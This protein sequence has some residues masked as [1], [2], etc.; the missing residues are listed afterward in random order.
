MTDLAYEK[1]SKDAL[2]LISTATNINHDSSH[3]DRVLE[4]ALSIANIVDPYK[5][6][7]DRNILKTCVLLH[8]L[9]Y[10]EYKTNLYTWWFEGS[11]ALKVLNKKIDLSFL[12]EEERKIISEAIYRHV[13]SFPIRTLN[14]KRNLYVQIL[15]DADTLDMFSDDRFKSITVNIQNSKFKNF[16][17]II[18]KFIYE[19]IYYFLNLQASS[20]Y[21]FEIKNV[22][23]FYKKTNFRYKEWN[24][25]GVR[26]LICIHGY[27]DT[28]SMFEKFAK[29]FP[30]HIHIISID[31]PMSLEKTKIYSIEEL[32][33]YI[34]VFCIKNNISPDLV[35]GF[36][37]GGLVGL[38][39]CSRF[40]V[41]LI[42]LNSLPCLLCKDTI[43]YKIIKSIKPILQNKFLLLIFTRVKVIINYFT[44]TMNKEALELIRNNPKSTLG[45]VINALTYDGR[46]KFEANDFV[47]KLIFCKDDEVLTYKRY[48]KF[49]ENFKDR[50]TLLETGGH[51]TGTQYWENVYANISEMLPKL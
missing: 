7:V 50:T 1:I 43:V 32:A 34:R 31:L 8:D 45:T 16:L 19:N 22:N 12:S 38:E 14:K 49:I 2:G 36:S 26:T 33:S 30:K 27:A 5:K 21:L 42:M 41:P 39:Y 9:A 23:S 13:H 24:L 10:L 28:S 20:A 17:L 48:K 11:L 46:A 35:I 6:I 4:N 15:Q 47:K 25:D 3:I 18:T 37:L 40:N 29:M 44:N 51:A